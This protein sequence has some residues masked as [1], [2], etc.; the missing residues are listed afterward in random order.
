M[1]E[2]QPIESSSMVD[3]GFDA[4]SG[5]L[6]ITFRS[7]KRYRYENVPAEVFDKLMSADSAGK[8]FASA[9]RPMYQ[10][11]AVE[12]VDLS[13]DVDDESAAS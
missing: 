10:A 9:I 4:D 13:Q 5:V 11:I 12:D 1:M 7:G 8:F 6:E 2:R 3:A